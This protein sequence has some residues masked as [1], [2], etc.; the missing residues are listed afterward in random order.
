[1]TNITFI[2]KNNQLIS[3]EAKGHSGYAELGSDIICASIST[4]LQMTEINLKKIYLL[5]PSVTIRDGFMK[6]TIKKSEQ[7]KAQNALKLLFIT[8]KEIAKQNSK[9]IN[10]EVKDEV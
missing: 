1:M 7:D 8:L 2:R 6:L 4:A 10:M 3:F 9:Y 5:S